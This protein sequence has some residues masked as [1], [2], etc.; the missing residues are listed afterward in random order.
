MP[1]TSTFAKG[2]LGAGGK[3]R[4]R[5]E[6]RRWARVVG[7]PVGGGLASVGEEKIRDR[8]EPSSRI[9]GTTSCNTGPPSG[10]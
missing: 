7:A 2:F 1:A 10:K 4:G 5:R 8:N 3:R 9:G 6:V